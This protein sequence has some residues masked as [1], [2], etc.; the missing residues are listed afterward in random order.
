MDRPLRG[1]KS[2]TQEEFEKLLQKKCPWHPGANHAAIDCNSGG[3]KKN[4]KPADKEPEDDDQE[5]QG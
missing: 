4:K 2:T 3:G 5:D 1:K